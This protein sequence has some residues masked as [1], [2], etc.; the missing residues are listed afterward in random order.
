MGTGVPSSAAKLPGREA[1]HL[2]AYNA[3]VKMDWSY[4]SNPPYACVTWCLIEQQGQHF[5]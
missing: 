3:E 5:T 1:N 2:P 4:T